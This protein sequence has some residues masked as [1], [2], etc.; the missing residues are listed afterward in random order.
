VTRGFLFTLV[1]ALV[2]ACGDAAGGPTAGKTVVKGSV[3]LSPSTPVCRKGSSCSKPL[4]GFRL[5]FSRRGKVIGRVKTDAHARYRVA[6]P[7]GRYAV[8]TPRRGSLRPRRVRVPAAASAVVNFKF[9]A[10]IR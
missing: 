2:A 10:G 9:D 7:P 3:V 5:V 6:L 4:P 1:V 8:T